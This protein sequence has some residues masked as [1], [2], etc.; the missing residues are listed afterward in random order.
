MRILMFVIVIRIRAREGCAHIP[1]VVC[2]RASM[3]LCVR[4][5]GAEKVSSAVTWIIS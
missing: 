1:A 3:G 4:V 2:L 5:L